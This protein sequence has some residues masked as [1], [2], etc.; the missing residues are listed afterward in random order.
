MTGRGTFFFRTRKSDEVM[1]MYLEFMTRDVWDGLV[2]GTTLIGLS[3]AVLQLLKNYQ[4]YL[5]DR[6]HT[7][8]DTHTP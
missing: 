4:H 8:D 7:Q 6:Q 1:R 5:R 3:L 2:I